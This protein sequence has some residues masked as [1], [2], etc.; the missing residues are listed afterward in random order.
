MKGKK[1]N[2]TRKKE[3][4]RDT[5]RR[6]AIEKE[7]EKKG[8]HSGLIQKTKEELREREQKNTLTHQG[9]SNKDIERRIARERKKREN[10]KERKK[11]NSGLI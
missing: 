9:K 7:G 6:I 2:N 4:N 10:K 11:D 8:R 3:S 5:E 1:Y